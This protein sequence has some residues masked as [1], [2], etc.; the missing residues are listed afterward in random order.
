MSTQ[1]QPGNATDAPLPKWFLI[2]LKLCP[3]SPYS[4]INHLGFGLES[5]H[6][7]P[8]CWLSIT[9][10]G[11]LTLSAE[12]KPF[13][14]YLSI[15]WLLMFGKIVRWLTGR[16]CSCCSTETKM[17]SCPS[18]SSRSWWS[19]WVRGP[20]VNSDKWLYFERKHS[21]TWKSSKNKKKHWS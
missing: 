13:F 15:R 9:Y 7:I 14:N 3:C 1:T 19:P 16:R 21:G 18:K 6:P 4:M 10:S 20:Q 2:Q 11:H 8:A 12:K 17:E 5:L